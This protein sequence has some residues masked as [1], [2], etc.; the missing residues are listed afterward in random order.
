MKK[1]ISII[2]SIS[3]LL[4]SAPLAANAVD[5]TIYPTIVVPGYSASCLYAVEDDGEQRQIWGS[6]EALNIGEVVLKYIAELGMGLTGVFFGSSEKFAK[7]LSN[8]LIELLGDIAYNPDGTPVKETVTYPNDPAITNYKYLLDELGGMHAAETEIMSDIADVYGDNGYE[9]L[10]SFQTDFRLNIVDAIEGLDD[11]IDAVLE[12]T[13]AEKVNIFAVSYGGQLTASYLNVYGHL[14]KVNNAV[15]TVPAI[16][17]AA[18]AYDVISENIRFDEETLFYFLENGM[19][20]E[21]D[22]NW[23]M[24]AHSLG[25]L[26]DLLNLVVKYGIRDILG[27]WGSI[28]DFIPAEYYEELKSEYLDPAES[29]E[30]IRKSDIFHYEI[31]PTMNEKLTAAMENGTNIYIVSGCDISAVTGLNVQSDGIIHLN[32]ATGA[33]S[34]PLGLRY[35]DGFTGKYTTCTD[36]A[37]NHLSPSMN[38]DASTCY[39]PEQT[40]FI[41]G[42]FHGMTWKDEYTRNLCKKLLFSDELIDVFDFEEFPQFRYSTN[43]CYTVDFYFGDSVNSTLTSQDTYLTIK[44]LSDKYRLN[45]LGISSYGTELEF[46]LPLC[47]IL[48]PGETITFDFNGELPCNSFITTDV[49]VNYVLIG[50][51]TPQGQRNLT[52]SIMNGENAAYDASK[53]YSL[54]KYESDFDKITPDIIVSLLSITGL[55]DYLRMLF[56]A[57]ISIF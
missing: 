55:L 11:Y 56:D 57:F 12:Y 48:E 38:I 29:A 49:C 8:G 21:E 36:T 27:Y 3:I 39:L 15:L 51:I 33:E 45:I 47:T 14:G 4:L 25:F 2:L 46:E 28:W 32:G 9:Y 18:L 31:L 54:L 44:N 30:L 24:K 17:G 20:L 5:D 40:W 41:S 7:T 13:G 52:F 19:M 43:V 50:S 6:F 53:P 22:I 35:S 34:S 10:F 23:L 16:G 37:H 42:L 26:D 1:L